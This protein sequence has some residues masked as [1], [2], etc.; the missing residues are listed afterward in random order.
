MTKC[1]RMALAAVLFL[2]AA[3]PTAFA[4]DP[5]RASGRKLRVGTMAIAPGLPVHL[6]ELNG[7]FKDAGLNIEII[8]FPTGAPIN[9]AMAADELDI[10]VSGMA[11]V[12]ALATGRYTYIGDGCIT[13]EG[14]AIYARKD[15][16]IA[17]TK[18]AGKSFL[19]DTA[20]VRGASI[21]GPLAT[22]VHFMAIKYAES[23]GLTDGDFK[24]VS[25]DYPQA[26]Q[27]FITGQGDLAATIT[28]YSSQL[29]NAGYVKVC[30][31]ADVM[32]A[33]L[34][35]A[36][37]VQKNLMKTM[38]PD[39]VAFLKCY[40]RACEELIGNPDMRKSVAKKWYA[41]EGRNYTD[42]D[43]DV[44]LQ[45]QTY[46]TLG[47]LMSK[48]YPFGFTMTNIVGFFVDQGMIP[49][50]NRDNVAASLDSSIVEGL[51]AGK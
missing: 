13:L 46:P 37:Y 31:L 27:A 25:M 24:M 32:G 36:V 8:I 49:E 23:F 11:S 44:E 22:S 34:V 50:E 26:Y 4:A 42:A 41:S 35:D 47:T 28:P 15:S 19:G 40:Y 6:A 12:Y 3:A 5:G 1:V 14:Q 51:K 17:K 9:E 10:A 18:E 7:Y 38:R 43:L 45:R 33:P 20:T 39:M 30:D 16:P 21:L 29:E 48:R 2:A